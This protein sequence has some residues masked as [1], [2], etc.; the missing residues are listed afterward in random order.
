MHNNVITDAL[1]L[2]VTLFALGMIESA[3]DW[4]VSAEK[5]PQYEANLPRCMQRY[6]TGL[7]PYVGGMAIIA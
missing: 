1:N 3:E 7:R 2:D 4:L 5:T 6:P